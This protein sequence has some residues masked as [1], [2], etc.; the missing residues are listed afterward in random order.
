MP[1][2]LLFIKPNILIDKT[3][4]ARLADFGLLTIISDPTK[5]TASSSF[6][7]CGTVR[8]MS[9]ELLDPDQVDPKDS[10]P[11]KAS[12]CYAL[13]MV[14]YEVLSGQFP[15]EKFRDIIVIQKVMKGEW[16]E[17]PEGVNGAWFTDDVWS[18][19][20]L[21][22]AAQPEQRPSVDAVLECLEQVPRAWNPPHSQVEEVLEMNE[23]DWDFTTVSESLAL[24]HFTSR[25]LVLITSLVLY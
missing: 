6:T 1:S 17:R 9:P 11:T 19:L 16:P 3:G 24:T 22:W 12:D 8:W 2:N 15:F 25:A 10:K 21:C 4:H 18:M 14:I 20:N 23:D 13:G 5:F 7:I